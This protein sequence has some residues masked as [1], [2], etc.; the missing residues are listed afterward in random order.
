MGCRGGFQH[1]PQR[2]GDFKQDVMDFGI[3]RHAVIPHQTDQVFGQMRATFHHRKPQHT[4]IALEG[5][6]GPEQG[7]DGPAG[8]GV[9]G[10]LQRPHT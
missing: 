10:T 8:D 9:Q 5:M 3:Q 4:G 7:R 6:H 2:I 1:H